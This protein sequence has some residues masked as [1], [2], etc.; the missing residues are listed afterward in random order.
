MNVI[1]TEHAKKRLKDSRQEG[2]TIP[3]VVDAAIGIPG[4]VPGATRI[5][6]FISSSGRFFDIVIRDISIG[7]LIITVIGK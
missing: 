2:I 7:R 4:K 5:R 1:V 6:G 3:D